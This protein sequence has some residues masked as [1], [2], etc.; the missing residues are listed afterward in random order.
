MNPKIL[1]TSF[2]T[3]PSP[4]GAST[5]IIEFVK[6]LGTTFGN[7]VLLTPSESDGFD[8]DF[9]P[10][11]QHVEV[12]CVEDNPIGRARLFRIAVEEVLLSLI[13]I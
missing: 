10:G 2:D 9:L 4:K 3:V 7:V 8:P 12:D 6:R 13:H 1:Y 11:V 5:H